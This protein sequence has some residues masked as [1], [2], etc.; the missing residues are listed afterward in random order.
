MGILP[1][2]SENIAGQKPDE[3]CGVVALFEDNGVGYRLVQSLRILQ[4]RGQESAGITI[5]ENNNHRTYKGMGLVNEVFSHVNIYANSDRGIGHV[6]YS[7]AGSST[8]DNAQPIYSRVGKFQISI[9]HN[10]EVTNAEELREDL[11][12]MGYSFN[13]TSDTEVILRLL[14]INLAK[15][16]DPIEALKLT[17]GKI[18]GAYSLVIMINDRVF[19]VRDPNA[20]RPLAVGKT[21]KGYG[22][23]S[24]NVVFDQLGGT[25]IRDLYPGEIIEIEKDG[26][27]SY[28]FGSPSPAH[29][30]FEYVYFA[31][32]DSTMDG[33]NIFEVRRKLGE[34]LAEEA[35]VN[36]DIVVPVPDSGRSHALGFSSKSGI[37]FVEGLIKNRYVDRTFIMPTQVGRANEIDI[38][39]HP[40][41]EIVKD[42]RVVLVDDSIVRG[43]TMRKLVK[44]L[45]D[46]GA[47]E[48][49]VRV[50]SPPIKYPCYLG[51]DM[52]TKD[53]FIARDGKSFQK[54]AEEFGADSVG[55]ISVEGLINAIG[56]GK[57]N[58]C[59]G[60]LTGVYPIRIKNEKFRG[61]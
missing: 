39:L 2:E 23:A 42:K 4:H 11:E 28:R 56:L 54:L 51:I 52:K 46:A 37:P 32:P 7:T 22:I 33:R 35:P 16:L 17:F 24:E 20:I 58:L 34:I 49:H 13:T 41:K 60:C 6:R 12:S 29:C 9:G 25:I 59:L 57:D 40:I 36:A 19:G 10:G 53:Q 8:L 47:K 14:A 48:V 50:G 61:F 44:M 38:K 26:F 18:V 45:R 55:Y 1:R 3:K 30:M 15:G 5:I 21:E 31:R 43:N 27:K